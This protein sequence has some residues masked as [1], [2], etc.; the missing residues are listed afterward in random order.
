M[1]GKAASNEGCCRI[2]QENFAGRGHSVWAG[3][4]I[5]SGASRTSVGMIA[6]DRALGD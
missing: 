2:E 6:S 3:S 1:I 4:L 5:Q